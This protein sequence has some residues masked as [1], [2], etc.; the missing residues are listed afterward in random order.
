MERGE[1]LQQS[2]LGSE[3]VAAEVLPLEQGLDLKYR[4]RVNRNSKF[5][6]KALN[7]NLLSSNAWLTGPQYDPNIIPIKP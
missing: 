4:Q 5:E 3:D 2:C 6:G 7:N 1:D